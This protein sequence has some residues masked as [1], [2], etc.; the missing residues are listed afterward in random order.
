MD[1]KNQPLH[2]RATFGLAVYYVIYII[3]YVTVTIYPLFFS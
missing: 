3:R 2:N 1:T